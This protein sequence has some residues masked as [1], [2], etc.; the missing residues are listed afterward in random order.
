MRIQGGKMDESSPQKRNRTLDAVIAAINLAA[1]GNVAGSA[2][3]QSLS[4][5]KRVENKID[6]LGS[7]IERM[8]EQIKALQAPQQEQKIIVGNA[9]A[10]DGDKKPES[11]QQ[12]KPQDV[13]YVRKSTEFP[14]YS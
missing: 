2:N 4:D 1:M 3:G 9:T 8:A 7:K 5:A 11:L 13:I 6:E 10:A 12:T 14:F